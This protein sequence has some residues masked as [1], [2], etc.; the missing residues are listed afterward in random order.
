M[1]QVLL[2]GLGGFLGS[3]IRFLIG[4]LSSRYLVNTLP[5]STLIINLIGSFLIGFIIT[6]IPKPDSGFFYLMIPGFLGG[7]TTYSA[8]SNEATLLIHKE[9]YSAFAIYVSSQVLGGIILCFLGSLS[10]KMMIKLISP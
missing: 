10:A 1:T 2:V 7:F 3:I 6:V 9:L 8:F 5:L 4:T